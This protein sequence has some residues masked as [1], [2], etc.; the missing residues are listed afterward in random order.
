MHH[1]G[2]HGP[3]AWLKWRKRHYVRSS[4]LPVLVAQPSVTHIPQRSFILIE[5]I[6]I[7][8][9]QQDFYEEENDISGKFSPDTGE[10]VALPPAYSDLTETTVFIAERVLEAHPH[11]VQSYACIEAAANKLAFYA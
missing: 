3:R 10:P 6:I 9:V 5:R 7:I 8:V 1:Y 2:R 4:L 11:T